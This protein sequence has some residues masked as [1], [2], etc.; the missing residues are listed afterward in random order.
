M[1]AALPLFFIFYNCTAPPAASVVATSL[2]GALASR[3]SSSFLLSSVL[4]AGNNAY[5]VQGSTQNISDFAIAGTFLAQS[6]ANSNFGSVTSSCSGGG[7]H[8]NTNC[9]AENSLAG[10]IY[11]NLNVSGCNVTALQLAYTALF[12]P[13]Q[14]SSTGAVS[15]ASGPTRDTLTL[16]VLPN[17]TISQLPKSVTPAIFGGPAAAAEYVADLASLMTLASLGPALAFLSVTA[18]QAGCTGAGVPTM[19][20]CPAFPGG[21]SRSLG[22]GAIAGIVVGSVAGALL[23][24]GIGW[25]LWKRRRATNKGAAASSSENYSAGRRGTKL[26]L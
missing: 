7:L 13:P 17:A 22:K 12:N 23:L 6:M 11:V 26:H 5:Y 25:A 9:T 8:S 15:F 16:G 2:R 20:A 10:Q 4:P 3:L 14:G 21:S 1:A 19:G 24:A 18:P